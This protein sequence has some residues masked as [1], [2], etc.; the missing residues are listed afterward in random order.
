MIYGLAGS[1][2]HTC[3]YDEVVHERSFTYYAHTTFDE[4]RWFVHVLYGILFIHLNEVVNM[5]NKFYPDEYE[6]P[7]KIV[8]INVSF[9]RSHPN[10]IIIVY[11]CNKHGYTYLHCNPWVVLFAV[12][13]LLFT[14]TQSCLQTMIR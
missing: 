13:L 14:S 2:L 4:P 6:P 3:E 7:Q 9:D 12:I 8:H 5:Y 10:I 11:I 1:F